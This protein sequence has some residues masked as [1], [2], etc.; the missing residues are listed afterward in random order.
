M[1][2][3]RL[4]APFRASA[5]AMI[6]YLLLGVLAASPAGAQTAES[7]LK[8][9]YY[10]GAEGTPPT[11]EAVARSPL[12]YFRN[13][14][15]YAVFREFVADQMGRSA[16]S[17]ADFRTLVADGRLRDT[18]PCTGEILAAGIAN[19]QLAWGDPRNCYRGERLIEAL[20]ADRW[21]AVAAAGCYNPKRAVPPK[22][23]K[24]S[25][26]FV[27]RMVQQQGTVSRTDRSL[28]LGAVWHPGCNCYRK[29]S[30]TPGLHLPDRA[31]ASTGGVYRRCEWIED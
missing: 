29:P 3:V 10:L 12:E 1:R 24:P 14:Q 13:A 5:M 11:L 21:V 19:G 9:K 20:V 4:W 26:R 6:G 28:H 2:H 22:P 16:L 18:T 23:A 15:A 27:C 8:S 30:L 25:G 7:F 31:T 17:D